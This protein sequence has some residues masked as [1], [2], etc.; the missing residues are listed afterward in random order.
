M[1]SQRTAGRASEKKG[2]WFML[3]LACALLAA[4]TGYSIGVARGVRSAW[5]ESLDT[6][7][8]RV[9]YRMTVGKPKGLDGFPSLEDDLVSVQAVL[10]HPKGTMVRLAMALQ[11][12][13]G[14]AGP[15]LTKAT[16]MCKQLAWPRCDAVALRRMKR[17]LEK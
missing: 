9:G 10:G 16:N 2:P 3:G 8:A 14:N 4:G 7:L 13:D 11:D 12:L 17:A 1:G 15:A 5:Q 6:P